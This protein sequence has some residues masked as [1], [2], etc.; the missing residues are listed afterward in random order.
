MAFGEVIGSAAVAF[1]STNIDGALVLVVYFAAAKDGSDGFRRRHVWVGQIMG[2]TVI[3]LLSLI[4]TAV[5]SLLPTHYAGFLGFVPLCIGLWRARVWF[6]KEDEKTE[7]S[8]GYEEFE[9]RVSAAEEGLASSTIERESPQPRWRS[10]LATVFSMHSLK[11]ATVTIG[12]GGDNVATYIPLLVTYSAGEIVVTLAVFYF[13]LVVWIYVAGRFVSFKLVA[14]FIDKY[15]KYLIPV[16]MIVLGIYI[17][18]SGHVF[19]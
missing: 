5:G 18:W 10:V 6:M 17:L 8:T 1:A 14:G 13:L 16:A 12:N 15:G 11:M 7:A 2:F 19:S 4:G 9:A 3:V